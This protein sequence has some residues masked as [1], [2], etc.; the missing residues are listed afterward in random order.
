MTVNSIGNW[1]DP[2]ASYVPGSGGV[3]KVGETEDLGIGSGMKSGKASA[4][5]ECHTCENRRYQDGSSEMVS[6]KSPTKISKSAVAT[7]VRAHENEHVSNA[8]KKAAMDGG[9]VLQASVTIKTAICPEC[10]TSYVA[11]GETATK[12]KYS[13][14]DNPYQ[15]LKKQQEAIGLV[16]M[17]FDEAA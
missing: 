13:N 10:G 16:G 9:K 15:K 2:Y 14:E 5:E 17:N 6:F 7:A 3:S 1:G 8:Y 4:A 12:I 11:G